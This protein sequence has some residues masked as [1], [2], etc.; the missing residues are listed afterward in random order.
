M[1]LII[2]DLSYEKDVSL[3]TKIKHIVPSFTWKTLSLFECAK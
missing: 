3:R 2:F 1:I